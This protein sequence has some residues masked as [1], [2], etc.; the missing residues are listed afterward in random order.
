MQM[1]SASPQ[2]SVSRAGGKRQVWSALSNLYE[3]LSRRKS[4]CQIE[5]FQPKLKE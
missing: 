5:T 2:C 1:Y 4:A 3:R